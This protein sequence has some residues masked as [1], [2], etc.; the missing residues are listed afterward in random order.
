MG[1]RGWKWF[2]D[3]RGNAAMV[4]GLCAVPVIFIATGVIECQ[5]MNNVKSRVQAA[6]D[7]AALYG[8]QQLSI[9][10]T[11]QG[12]SAIVAAATGVGNTTLSGGLNS[13]PVSFT[14]TVDHSNNSVTVT[15][16]TD[17]KPLI[18]FLGF[19]DQIVNASAT[20]DGLQKSAPLCILQTGP[21]GALS[22]NDTAH[23]RATGCAVHAND[24]ITVASSAGI[25]AETVQ[26]TGM[27]TG[28]VQPAGQSGALHIDDPFTALDLTPPSTCAASGKQVIAGQTVVSLAPGVHCD[29]YKVAGKATLQLL[30]GE[31]YFMQPL[32]IKQNASL[33][34][35]DVALIFGLGQAFT[36]G[37]SGTVRIT[38]RKSGPFA[39]FLIAT[40]RTNTAQFTIGS[41][42][43]SQLL[44]TIYIPDAE[45]N[46]TTTGNVAQDSSWSVIVAKTLTLSQNPNLIINNNYVGSGVPVPQGVGPMVN[47]KPVLVQ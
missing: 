22:V 47:G 17:H 40:T 4:F 29:A 30:P 45:L 35:N 1:F 21:S 19:G 7:A 8:A 38:A 12:D 41:G 33:L 13:E 31:H 6:T 27:I 36:F 20:A 2:G 37:D 10:Q 26:A 18:G 16:Q 11:G 9:A 24:D 3:E 25:Q 43:V 39:G 15:A 44:G 32:E 28:P 42:N 23:I 34:G 5:D 46:I 14:V